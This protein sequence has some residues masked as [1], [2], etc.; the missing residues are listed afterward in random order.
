VRF[1]DGRCMEFAPAPLGE[2]PPA[3]ADPETAA[4]AS[5]PGFHPGAVPAPPAKAPDVANPGR[6]GTLPLLLGAV[7]G[8]LLGLAVGGPLG[9][10]LGAVA[11][12]ALAG[13]GNLVG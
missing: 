7:G 13:L 11:G 5:A 9:A 8:A 6:P 12:L 2:A 4:L 1:P 3:A 10:L